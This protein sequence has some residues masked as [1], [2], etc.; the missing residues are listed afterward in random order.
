MSEHL[1][2]KHKLKNDILTLADMLKSPYLSEQ[3][4]EILKMIYI[5]EMDYFSIADKLNMS[6]SSVKKKHCKI[7][8]K[9]NKIIQAGL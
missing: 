4:K 3:E 2:T 1:D 6:D 9:V 7:L 8:K 5:E